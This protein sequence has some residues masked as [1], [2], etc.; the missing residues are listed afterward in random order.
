MCGSYVM[1]CLLAFF[2]YCIGIQMV[3]AKE[4]QLTPRSYSQTPPGMW[5]YQLPDGTVLKQINR[6]G[7]YKAAAK[8]YKN[9]G[10]EVP[11]NLN[12]LIDRQTC[13]RVPGWC[14][15]DGL[16]NYLKHVNINKIVGFFN[17]VCAGI[18][19]KLSGDDAFVSQ[20][21]ADRR[22]EI[23]SA[24][25][26]NVAI[27]EG[28]RS[29]SAASLIADGMVSFVGRSTPYDRH[30]KA[31]AACGCFL[32]AKVHVSK[33]ILKASGDFDYYSKCWMLS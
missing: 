30:L 2:S 17:V 3:E 5:Q 33:D 26:L 20:E 23:C 25:P 8:G 24:C 28:C 22:A 29:C 18:S 10:L 21:E 19:A 1:I 27:D 12:Q 16:V 14:E 4:P 15:I 7:L 31:C 11:A 6:V 13:K 9:L 32:K